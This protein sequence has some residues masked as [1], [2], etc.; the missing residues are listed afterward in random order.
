MCHVLLQNVSLRNK[1][2]YLAAAVIIPLSGFW[3][4]PKWGQLSQGSQGAGGGDLYTCGNVAPRR[5]NPTPRLGGEGP[6]PWAL[7]VRFREAPGI[8]KQFNILKAL[9]GKG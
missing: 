2:L 3:V 9:N 1:L 5:Q 7:E 4:V 6:L 8:W